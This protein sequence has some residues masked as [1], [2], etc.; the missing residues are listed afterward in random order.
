MDQPEIKHTFFTKHIELLKKSKFFKD[1][2]LV[3]ITNIISNA[4][5]FFGFLLVAKA[6]SSDD[7]GRLATILA[8]VTGISDLSN[9][10]MNAST[11]RFTAIFKSKKESGKINSL[12][13]TVFTNI[14][15]ISLLIIGVFL[16]FSAPVT[17]LFLKDTTYKGLIII[18]S[19]GILIALLY[20]FFS[21]V[22]Q[23]LQDFK[24]YFIYN[25]LLSVL[26]ISFV[27]GFFFFV[28]LNLTNVVIILVFLPVFSVISS[29]Y[30]LKP[31]RISPLLYDRSLQKE[32][33]SFGKWMLLWSVAAILQSRVST[34]LLASMMNVTE[35]SYYD[36]AKKFSNIV[37]FGMGAFATVLN[38]KLAS[39]TDRQ[40]IREFVSKSK[41]VVL[42][43]TVVLLASAFLFPIF[44]KFL[45]GD[46]YGGAF[47]PMSIIMVSLISYVWTLPY[48]SGLYSLGKSKVFFIQAVAGLVIESGISIILIPKFGAVGASVSFGITYALVLL[49]SIFYFKKYISEKTPEEKDDKSTDE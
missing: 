6:L 12:L 34:Y 42:G 37:M 41:L 4:L 48:N 16:I 10:G 27:A 49:M 29:F 39:L 45:Y 11:I 46:K 35:V 23:G 9:L 3:F 32:T 24:S 40:K 7:Y 18:S 26:K 19:F 22:F 30:F 8:V 20:S 31:Y 47:I 38:T 25:V 2:S 13:S 21:S 1:V 43:F 5:N 36:I 14:C 17:E 44:L 28:G 33:F 15:L